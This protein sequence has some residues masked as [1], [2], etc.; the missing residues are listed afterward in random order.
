MCMVKEKEYPPPMATHL[1]LLP[2]QQH[3][4]QPVLKSADVLKVCTP[5]SVGL[6]SGPDTSWN[7]L[8]PWLPILSIA[9]PVIAPRQVHLRD[10]AKQIT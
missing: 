4:H 3:S 5:V 7:M 1:D 9:W 2:Y 6:G 10:T 8:T